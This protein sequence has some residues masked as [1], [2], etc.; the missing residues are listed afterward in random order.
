MEE[1]MYYVWQQRLFSAILTADDS[2]L[3]IIHP[4]LRNLDAGPDFFNAKVKFGDITW[5]GNVEMHVR[6]S[7]WFR[8]NHQHDVAYDSVVLHV[9]LVA[10]AV[11]RHPSGEPIKT[12]LMRIP[13]DV[14]ERY[15]ELTATSANPFSSIRCAAHIPD[16]PKVI[17][18][19]WL[20]ALATQRLTD[21]MRRIRDIVDDGSGSWQEAFYVILARSLGT[22]IN[23][24]TF[25]RLAR[26]LPFSFLQKHLDDPLQ[27]R[28]L[29]L[30]QAG[31]ISAN[32]PRVQQEYDFLRA[33]FSLTPLP[34]TAW[35]QAKRRPQAAPN[36]RIE[37][38]ANILTAHPN[39]FSEVL[40]AP[41]VAALLR[42]FIVPKGIGQQTAHSILINAVAPILLA[43]GQW[44]LDDALC[45]R[46]LTLL[47][48]LPA[49]A[50]RYITDWKSS[51]YESH[52]AFE[53]QALLH[54]YREY[55]E[56][57]KCMNCRIGCW[58][59]RDQVRPVRQCRDEG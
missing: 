24:D 34:S 2:P 45:D 40:D 28:A 16:V 3:E 41:D 13:A 52:S 32:E 49:E 57:H 18:Q 33:K 39:L 4:G 14:M 29:L 23:S 19:D 50:N 17:M 10:D 7:D 56:P 22:G 46:A 53:T 54:L 43:Y 51:G 12:A 37:A 9:V 31:L 35:R 5:A 8:H 27:V 11:I 21:K 36:L 58:L 25:E 59:I 30:G 47:E 42:L 38:L 6:A 55:C 15:R 48:H 20:T 1:L 44:K 26:S